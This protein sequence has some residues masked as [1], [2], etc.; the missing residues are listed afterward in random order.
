MRRII[1]WF[2]SVPPA[3]Y[4]MLIAVLLVSCL[5]GWALLSFPLPDGRSTSTAAPT[6]TVDPVLPGVTPTETASPT[7][8]PTATITPTPSPSLTRPTATAPALVAPAAPATIA[9]PEGCRT[10]KSADNPANPVKHDVVSNPVYDTPRSGTPART[11]SFPTPG[12]LLVEVSWSFQSEPRGAAVQLDVTATP[13]DVIE[14][15]APSSRLSSPLVGKSGSAVL[16]IQAWNPG[17]ATW[18]A[19]FTGAPEGLVR[20]SWTDPYTKD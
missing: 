1:S 7:A 9:E 17:Q 8:T 16:W 11:D 5:A 19:S 12:C 14:R 13:P 15:S 3:V 6:R 10:Q 18:S 4:G 2:A 20:S